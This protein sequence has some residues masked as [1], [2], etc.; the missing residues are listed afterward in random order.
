MD[1]EALLAVGVEVSGLVNWQAL[2]CLQWWQLELGT[3]RRLLE[4]NLEKE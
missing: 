4:E 1:G 3:G 2:R